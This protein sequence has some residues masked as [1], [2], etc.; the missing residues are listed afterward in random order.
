MH[1]VS[2][3][4]LYEVKP[5]GINTTL[6]MPGYFRTNFLDDSSLLTPKNEMAEYKNVRDNQQV[7]QQDISFN[8]PGD[9]DKAADVMIEVAGMQKPPFHLFLG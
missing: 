5:F 6:V 3:A 4:L 1:G 7:H 2:E 9:P 8:Q